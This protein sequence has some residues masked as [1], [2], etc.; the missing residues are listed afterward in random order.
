MLSTIIDYEN[1]RS[2]TLCYTVDRVTPYYCL[3]S[4]KIQEK[5]E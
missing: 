5:D 4:D 2:V 3:L 1:L